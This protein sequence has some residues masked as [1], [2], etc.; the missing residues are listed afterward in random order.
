MHLR[1]RDQSQ[2]HGYTQLVLFRTDPGYHE[3]LHVERNHVA[4]V[5]EP[6]PFSSLQATRRDQDRIIL[7]IYINLRNKTGCTIARQLSEEWKIRSCNE[8]CPDG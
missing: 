7:Y 6:I 2:E 4:A 8:G 1:P 3:G 5:T